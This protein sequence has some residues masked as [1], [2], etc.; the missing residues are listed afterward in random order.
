M[1]LS[2]IIPIYFLLFSLFVFSQDSVDNEDNGK[3]LVGYI[4][5]KTFV[6]N[7]DNLP[8]WMYTNT[9][10]TIDKKS[11]YGIRAGLLN[12]WIIGDNSFLSLGGGVNFTDGVK[13]HL[14]IEELYLSYNANWLSIDLGI[15]HRDKKEQGLS[16]IN[17]DILWTGNAR[18]IPGVSFNTSAPVSIFN[19]LQFNAEFGHYELNDIRYVDKARVHHKSLEFIFK[20]SNN[21]KFSAGL[22]HYAQWAGVSPDFGK[23]ASG[24]KDYLNVFLGKSGGNQ[25]NDQINAIG[26]HIGSY[27]LNYYVN[28]AKNEIH[29]YHQS[30]FEDRSG[31]EL[32]NFPDGI[33]GISYKYLDHKFLK[34]LLFE[35][36]QTVSQSGRPRQTSGGENQQSGGDN[37]FS[38]SVYRSGWTYQQVIIGLPLITRYNS[39]SSFS[40]NRSYAFNFGVAANYNKLDY[41]LKITW[42]KNLGTYNVPL[43]IKEKAIYTYGNVNFNSDFG[44]IN[45]QVGYDYSNIINNSIG[46]GLGYQYN[47]N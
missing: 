43:I 22:S 7:N 45:L 18:S 20:I 29:L 38:N 14:T 16:I 5:G 41:S 1:L 10:N 9:N 12:K 35:Y 24:F 34:M 19:W 42:V 44:V 2:Y 15:K 39:N 37:Y 17:G 3:S 31:R 27:Q 21:Q 36:V 33:W 23:Q 25:R 30:L 26:N 32:N 13:N 28:M 11:T 4:S 6:T 46:F 40:N 47:L 8:F